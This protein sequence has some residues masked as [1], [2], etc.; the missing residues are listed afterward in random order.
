MLT[1]SVLLIS[2]VICAPCKGKIIYV[3][4]GAPGANDGSS[5]ADAYNYLQDALVDAD[6]AENPVEILVAQGIYKPDQ[7][8]TITFGDRSQTFRLINGVSIFGGYAG[9][10]GADPDARDIELYQT[11]LSGDL[12]D[13]DIEIINSDDLAGEAGRAENSYQIVTGSG[14]DETA[15]LDG[16]TITGGNADVF[17]D[18]NGGGLVNEYGSPQIINCTFSENSSQYYGGAIYN[19]YSSPILV[20]CTFILNSA[21]YGGGI[22]NYR[23][24]TNLNNC[25]FIDNKSNS[26]GGGVSSNGGSSI[27]TNCTFIDNRANYAGGGT[28]NRGDSL[29]INNSSFTGNWAEHEGGGINCSVANSSMTNCIFSKNSADYGGGGIRFDDS[30]PNLTGCTFIENSGRY[31]GGLYN[32]NS[33]LNLTN[34]KFIANTGYDYGGGMCNM[35]SNNLN[36]N[37]CI[38]IA[39]RANSNGGG[40][41]NNFS[42]LSFTNCTFTGNS[43]R[44]GNAFAFNSR[45]QW[46]QST[47]GLIDCILWDGGTEIWNNDNSIINISYSNIQNNSNDSIITYDPLFANPDGPDDIPGTEDDDLRLAPLSPCI[48]AGD[49]NYSPGSNKK[50]LDGNPRIVNGRVDMGAYE[51]QAIYVD[52]YGSNDPDQGELHGNGTEARPFETIQEAIDIAKDGQTVLVRPGVYSKIDFIGKAIMVAGTEGAA[53]IEASRSSH[54]PGVSIRDAVT[55]HTGEG[56]GSVLKNFIIRNNAMAISLNYG[57]SPTIRN[58]TIVDNNFGISAYENSNPDISNCIFWNNTDGDLFQCEARYSCLEGESPGAGNISGDPLF[59]DATND[60]YHLKSEGWRWNMQNGTWTY[61][62]ITSPCIDAGDPALPLGDEPL[63]APRDPNNDYGI[64]LYIN[65]GAYGGTCQA[66][67][68]PLD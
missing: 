9:F 32:D 23:G 49:P 63:S 68:P 1:A 45:N 28:Y 30:D 65:M 36:L 10:G 38:F 52:N 17:T 21:G 60:D 16:F 6:T 51:F 5:W 62:L 19:Y 41:Y 8:A 48:D 54:T 3:D 64:N 55:F 61:D 43:A 58:L 42:D 22:Y 27:I 14:T 35:S 59:V 33:N 46:F 29:I 57:S 66:S 31:G 13:D 18:R 39:N 53:V 20:N 2:L 25:T 44:N 4:T 40:M 47:V 50:D 12:N 11:I 7:G 37:N 15:V 56:P 34:C 26:T 67:I 24:D